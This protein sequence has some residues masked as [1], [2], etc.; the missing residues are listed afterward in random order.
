[1]FRDQQQEL[2]RLQEQLLLE[3]QQEQEQAQLDALLD[4]PADFG[5]ASQDIY[6]NYSNA[7]GKVRIYNTDKTDEDLESYS[8]EVRQPK[9]HWDILA[10]C[11]VALCLLAG[12]FAVLAWWAVRYLGG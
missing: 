10:L 2:K 4:D 3:E 12:I 9:K 7:Y 11:A 1:M 5:E 8:E 6:K